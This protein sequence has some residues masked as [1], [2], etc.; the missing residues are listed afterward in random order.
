ML[1]GRKLF[2]FFEFR[3][4]WNSDLMQDMY[5]YSATNF[6]KTREEPTDTFIAYP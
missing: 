1:K 5:I 2:V 6:L 4:Q 3:Y